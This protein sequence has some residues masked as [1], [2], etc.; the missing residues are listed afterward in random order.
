MKNN[1]YYQRLFL[2]LPKILPFGLKLLLILI[3]TGCAAIA[4][5]SKPEPATVSVRLK[6]THQIQF[7]GV[8]T[9][10]QEGY[11]EEENL[12]VKLDEVDFNHQATYENILAGDNEIGIG[13]PEELILARGQGKPLRAVAV[14]FRLSPSVYLAP[15]EANITTPQDFV[16]KTVAVIPGRDEIIYTAMLS[17]LGIDPSRINKIPPS[18]YTIKECWQTATVCPDYATNGLALLRYE[19]AD[20]TAIWPSE[21]GVSFY[22]D[23]I[24]TTDEFIEKHPDVVERFVR[25]TLKG[26][27]KAVDDLDLG[28][29]NTLAFNS[30]LDKGVQ[31]A[32]LE[33]SLPLIDTGEDKIGW[34]RPEI[35]QQ[36]HDVLLEQGLLTQPLDVT[37]TYTNEFVE[38]AYAQ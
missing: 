29:K 5:S 36:M 13:A 1:A 28:V 6:W 26:W 27:Q 19:G 31:L 12:T 34:M 11:Y 30:E 14:I 32:A 2:L 18:A 38:K 3:I 15:A 25:A 23:V 20:F 8:Y 4:S 10:Q 9:A 24:F 35:W 7:A 22:G 16:G 37:T 33:S 21:Y 17:N